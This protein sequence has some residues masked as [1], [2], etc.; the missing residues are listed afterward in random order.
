MAFTGALIRVGLSNAFGVNERFPQGL[1]FH[2]GT[3][4]MVGSGSDVL[5]TLNT[6]TGVAKR[7][8]SSN[9]FGVNERFPQGLA[10]DGT[11]LYMVGGDNEALYTLNT[12]T[13]VATIVGSSSQFGV[14]EDDPQGL[15]FHSGVLYMVGGDNTSLYTLNTTTGVAKRVG[16]SNQFGVSEDDPQGLAFHSGVLYMVG[17]DNT[18]LYTLNTT[19]GVATI[20]GHV[21]ANSRNIPPKGIASDGTNMYMVG[22]FSS[23][24]ALYRFSTD[25]IPSDVSGL[26]ASYLSS[27]SIRLNWNALS[28]ITNYQYRSQ[29]KG[30]L[31]WSFWI[32]LSGTGTT[33]DVTG[34]RP[35]T[36]YNF[37]VRGQNGSA[38]GGESN[39]ATA[40]TSPSTAPSTPTSL[41]V[42]THGLGGLR[43]TWTNP[44]ETFTQNQIRWRRE[45]GN[46][47][48]PQNVSPALGTSYDILTLPKGILHYVQVRSGN[49]A[50]YSDWTTAVTATPVDVSDA[51]TNVSVSPGNAIIDITWQH[52]SNTGGSAILRDEVRHKKSTETSWSS[53]A[54]AGTDLMHQLTGL[55]NNV[56]YNIEVRSVNAQGNSP[57]AATTATPRLNAVAAMFVGAAGLKN[58]NFTIGID[59]TNSGTGSA[60]VSGFTRDDLEIKHVSGT[61]LSDAGLDTPIVSRNTDNRYFISFSPN[62]DIITTFTLDVDGTVVI[63][64]EPHTV[65]VSAETISVNSVSSISASWLNTDGIKVNDFAIDVN[66]GRVIS[67][68]A[69]TDFDIIDVS[70]DTYKD[71]ITDYTLAHR[72]SGLYR[73]TF[74]ANVGYTGVFSIDIDGMVTDNGV[75]RPVS[76]N[77]V[78]ISVNT[79]GSIEPPRAQEYLEVSDWELFGAQSTVKIPQT[80]IRCDFS[81]N[82]DNTTIADSDFVPTNSNVTISRII[83]RTKEVNIIL[84]I[85]DKTEG[86]F[87]IRVKQNSIESTDDD[88]LDG[89]KYDR[90]SPPIRFDRRTDIPF[91]SSIPITVL[92]PGETHNILLKDFIS[93]ELNDDGVTLSSNIAWISISD[94]D[95]DDA[96]THGNNRTITIAPP[97]TITENVQHYADLHAA[98][99]GG[100]VSQRITVYVNVPPHIIGQVSIGPPE[101][102]VGQVADQPFTGTEL[103][104]DIT[105]AENITET[106]TLIELAGAITLR[107]TN[108]D[109]PANVLA[110]N[111][112]NIGMAGTRTH[113]RLRVPLLANTK[114]TYWLELTENAINENLPTESTK[115]DYDTTTDTPP[116]VMSPIP[117]QI[118]PPGGRS[119][120]AVDIYVSGNVNDNGIALS[121]NA[122]WITLSSY[123]PNNEMTH[124]VNRTITILPPVS[125]T[126]STQYFFTLTATGAGGSTSQRVSVFVDV[127][128]AEGRQIYNIVSDENCMRQD[129]PFDLPIEITP[130]ITTLPAANVRVD[131][132]AKGEVRDIT[133]TQT[134]IDANRSRHSV[135]ITPPE[136]GSGNINVF[137]NDDGFVKVV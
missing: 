66:F 122:D 118:L 39:T 12:T 126:E 100:M 106:D 50:L 133:R 73:L 26:T 53:W 41:A 44:T 51:P 89:P 86:V 40:T 56:V 18:S 74:D 125:I 84:D 120:I 43:A 62:D 115:V 45:G 34:L 75:S 48:T 16:S 11:N 99:P 94:Y 113:F 38:F 80:L 132:G 27:T 21:S 23:A 60:A 110:A 67:D 2:N 77:R 35:S 49:G 4:Y 32:T 25:T 36:T 104:H 65:T 101:N 85:A 31:S 137:V 76:I 54:N 134:D 90:Y 52:A 7:V 19:T 114:G 8:G 87:S 61:S 29:I 91:I 81:H 70:G 131:C 92:S 33:T 108:N 83:P 78:N 135:R 109:G 47:N 82:A 3:L 102:P 14:S 98:G 79:S 124:G 127:P 123:D 96:S 68:L 15:A 121:D 97:D 57:S 59:F 46:Y 129:E 42:V 111:L 5:Y 95:K 30:A 63:S 72:G 10:S 69:K 1:A 58:G 117:V 119:E 88:V 130:A 112:T 24:S 9:Q 128:P 64:G 116:P 103:W 17:G 71:M 93:G 20:V 37:Q 136:V 13:G 55:D 105:F 22:G 6:T 107:D 28:G